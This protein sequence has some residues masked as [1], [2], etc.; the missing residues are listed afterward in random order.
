VTGRPLDFLAFSAGITF[1]AWSSFPLPIAYAAVPEGT[2]PQP[3]PGFEDV[4]SVKLG[5]EGDFA[6][7]RDVALLPRL[8]LAYQP[9][10][11]PAQTGFHNHLDSDR[12]LLALGAG[13]RWGRLRLDVAGQLHD[14]AARTSTKTAGT[15]QDNPG[16]PSIRG[17]GHILFAAVELGIEL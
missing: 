13:L 7:G 4:I 12:V 6:L 5:V 3:P 17:S 11:V 8:G 2:P 10:P 14:L 9:S 15:P 1:E 16:F